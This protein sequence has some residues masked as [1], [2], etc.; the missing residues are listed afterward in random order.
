LQGIATEQTI[1]QPLS[2]L[3]VLVARGSVT[4]E[5]NTQTTTSGGLTG[6]VTD[7]SKAGVPD[8]DESRS[9]SGSLERLQELDDGFLVLPLQFFKMLTYV[10]C[11]AAVPHDRVAK[12]RG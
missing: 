8:A 12:R 5:L 7:Q 3:A 11:L 4:N 2:G 9:T 10:A 6:V 1:A